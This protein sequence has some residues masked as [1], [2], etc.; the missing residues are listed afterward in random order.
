M[1]IFIK[2]NSI[3]TTDRLYIKRCVALRLGFVISVWEM[4]CLGIR[5]FSSISNE[6]LLTSRPPPPLTVSV[7]KSPL[8]K[9]KITFAFLA[10][11][12]QSPVSVS[13]KE[14]GQKVPPCSSVPWKLTDRS[15]ISS[16]VVPHVG[17]PIKGHWFIFTAVRWYKKSC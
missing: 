8:R 15:V 2:S 12:C 14:H 5:D 7:P 4:G 16:G 13:W 3:C 11:A 9:L 1:Q 6:N 17:E 10:F